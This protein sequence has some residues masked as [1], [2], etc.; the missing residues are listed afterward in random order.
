LVLVS[1][2]H[3]VVIVVERALGV[4]IIAVIVGSG[5]VGNDVE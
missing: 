4:M 5:A 2:N 1:I 3:F